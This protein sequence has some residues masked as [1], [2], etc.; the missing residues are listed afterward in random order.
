MKIP[1]FMQGFRY[2]PMSEDELAVGEYLPLSVDAP[3]W[4][5]VSTDYST[6]ATII[7]EFFHAWAGQLVKNAQFLQLT[8]QKQKYADSFGAH[9]NQY[10]KDYMELI[11]CSWN[12]DGTYEYANSPVTGYANRDEQ[13]VPCFEDFADSAQWY[14][15]NGCGL[16]NG[17]RTGDKK[18]GEIRYGYFKELFDGKEYVDPKSCFQGTNTDNSEG[19][20]NHPTPAIKSPTPNASPTGGKGG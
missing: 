20:I 5:Q 6:E 18:A 9:L 1:L 4:M 17:G 2:F 13:N 7:H 16:L 19:I 14:V 15:T 12:T 3:E 8:F 11:G 10:P